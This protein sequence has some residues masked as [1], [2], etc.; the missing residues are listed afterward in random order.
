MQERPGFF[1]AFVIPGTMGIPNFTLGSFAVL[2]EARALKLLEK[3]A[4]CT[5][6]DSKELVSM[7]LGSGLFLAMG[8]L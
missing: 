2:A 8:S 5:W 4:D 7:Y 3:S 6:T 1:S